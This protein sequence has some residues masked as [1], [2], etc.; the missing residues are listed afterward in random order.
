MMSTLQGHGDPLLSVAMN[1]TLASTKDDGNK[2]RESSDTP[3]HGDPLLHEMEAHHVP[4]PLHAEFKGQGDPL[5][6]DVMEKWNEEAKE[7]LY[8]PMTEEP[9]KVVIHTEMKKA[10]DP[11][12]EEELKVAGEGS[13][14][15]VK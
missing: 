8:V 1:T 15:K 7:K 12:L 13:T 14:G 4:S 6:N 9:K 10:G 3:G 2:P 11:L 5:M